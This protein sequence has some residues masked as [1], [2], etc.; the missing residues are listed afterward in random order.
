M[1]FS[2]LFRL[3]LATAALCGAL[4]AADRLPNGGKLYAGQALVCASGHHHAKLMADG[5][6]VL[7]FR[8]GHVYWSAGTAGK[9]EH[10]CVAMQEDNNLVVYNDQGQAVWQS[11]TVN[12]GPARA[13][14]VLL[15]DGNLQ[16][17]AGG[18]VLWQTGPAPDHDH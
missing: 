13:D 9:A 15:E 6:F 16:V 14:L 10:G 7:R 11:G 2:R 8:D 17:V 3:S 1:T 5:D 12:Q 4:T 18:Q